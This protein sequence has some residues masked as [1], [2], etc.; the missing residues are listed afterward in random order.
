MKIR[1]TT[2][3]TVEKLTSRSIRIAY[4]PRRSAYCAVCSDLVLCLSVRN[5][6]E[7]LDVPEVEILRCVK[8]LRVHPIEKY[9]ILSGI[10]GR[11]VIELFRAVEKEVI[12]CDAMNGIA[13][14][15]NERV[16]RHRRQSSRAE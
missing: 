9:G 11:S 16:F 6:A 14:T 12:G 13:R 4:T 7:L 10:C 15:C 2:E 3:I 5:V 1:R 8:D